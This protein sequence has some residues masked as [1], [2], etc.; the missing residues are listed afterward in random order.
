[1]SA[2]SGGSSELGLAGGNWGGL[3][4]GPLPPKTPAGIRAEAQ[5]V[6]ATRPLLPA[7]LVPGENVRCRGHR[8]WPEWGHTHRP[9]LRAQGLGRWAVPGRDLS[10]R[11]TSEEAGAE[12]PAGALSQPVS[13]R[14][15]HVAS[16]GVL[17]SPQRPHPPGGRCCVFGEPAG[18][19]PRLSFPTWRAMRWQPVLGSQSQKDLTRRETGVCGWAVSPEGPRGFPR[20][21]VRA[22]S[23]QPLCR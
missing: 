23:G 7:P 21:P 9:R 14:C 10:V 11:D 12:G 8:P 17:G 3:R 22:G 15:Q 5:R 13:L 6:T 4:R 18:H 1:M 20:P 2:G 16:L 19:T